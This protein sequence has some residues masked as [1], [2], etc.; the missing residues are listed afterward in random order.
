VILRAVRERVRA[1]HAAAY[2][3]VVRASVDRN[4]V[5]KPG[6][7]RHHEVDG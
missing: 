4:L 6:W 7:V 5:G 2:E 1:E 3:P